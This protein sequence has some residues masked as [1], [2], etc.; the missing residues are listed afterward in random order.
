LRS[1]ERLRSCRY[2]IEN[3]VLNHSSHDRIDLS[4]IIVNWNVCDFLR[5]CL[6]S[7]EQQMLLARDRYEV[8]VVDNASGDQSVSMLRDEFPEVILYE[9]DEN[10]G[11]GRGCNKG[12]E[13]ARG[14]LVLLLNP[15]TLVVDHAIDSMLDDISNHPKTGIIGGRQVNEFGEFRRDAGG[16]F[17]TLA[18]VAWQYLFLG[19][20][21]PSRIAPPSHFLVGDPEG[22]QNVDWVS[23]AAMLIRRE[24]TGDQ[25]FDESFFMYGE[26]MDICDRIRNDGWEI[27]YTGAATITH[28]LGKSF[29]QQSDASVLQAI[30]KGPRAFFQKKNGRLAA[31]LFDLIML[32]GFFLRW[33]MFS[34]AHLLRPGK[35]FDKL[36][37]F[38]R[39]YVLITLRHLLPWS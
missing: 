7:I 3:D 27:A 39:R 9:S 6:N 4:I 34:L 35:D 15:D 8:I 10:L 2:P 21:L 5:A 11:F 18:N 28:Y 24:A 14:D 37:T 31:F 25:L 1:I 33:I 19:R 23:G 26:D 16:A 22:R 20:L 17:P 12:F 13:I 36:S 30:H 29:E 32:T 38:S